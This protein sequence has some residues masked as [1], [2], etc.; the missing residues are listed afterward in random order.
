MHKTRL[1]A[2][3]L[4]LAATSLAGPAA[5]ETIPAADAGWVAVRH[6]SSLVL[7]YAADP[8]AAG[9]I[10]AEWYRVNGGTCSD[11]SRPPKR[12][13]YVWGGGTNGGWCNLE[14]QY[15]PG[16]GPAGEYAYLNVQPAIRPALVC[17][18][19]GGWVQTESTCTR[20]DCTAA[21]VRNAGTGACETA[22]PAGQTWQA[23][24]QM[25]TCPL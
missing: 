25:C 4:G 14:G 3:A 2:A 7:G 21:Q 17:P 15:C 12:C 20:P 24:A 11:G 8:D 10:A 5:A 13:L 16:Y 23:S 18:S 1:I 19:T 9:A 6:Y 22:C